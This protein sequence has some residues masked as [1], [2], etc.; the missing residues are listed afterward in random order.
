MPD[1]TQR[2]LLLRPSELGRRVAGSVL[3]LVIRAYGAAAVVS[4]ALSDAESVRGKGYDAV[5]AVPNLLERY[6][7]ARYVVEHR[8][9]IRSTLQ[10]VHDNAPPPDQ[11]EAAAQQSSETLGRI[12]TSYDEAARALEDL[13]SIRPTNV[14]QKL[15]QVKDHLEQAWSTR[16]DLDSIRHLAD[17]AREV[18]PYLRRLDSLDLDWARAY[19]NLLSVLDNFAADEVVG[20]LGVMAVTAVL[21]YVLAQATGFWTRRGRPGLVAGTLQRLGARLFR[22]WYVRNLEYAVGPS[23]YAVARE[24]IQRDLVA[25]PRGTLDPEALD[26]LERWFRERTPD[27]PAAPG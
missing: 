21:A 9:E 27:E 17:Q 3:E 7:E 25:D 24:R 2:P 20:T 8:E 15:P 6:R 5:N 13:G 10:Y 19:G 23:F 26:A 14:V 12:T 22:S 18:T 1:V 11:L 4:V 16:P